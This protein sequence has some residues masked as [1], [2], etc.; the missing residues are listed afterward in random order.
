ME[1]NTNVMKTHCC[2]CGVAVLPV[3]AGWLHTCLRLRIFRYFFSD[4][5]LNAFRLWPV[6]G[7]GQVS[8]V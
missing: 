2:V 8:E 7:A 4:E 6:R 3:I 1:I 5:R